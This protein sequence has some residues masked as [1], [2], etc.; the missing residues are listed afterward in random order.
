MKGGQDRR[1]Q[2]T[3]PLSYLDGRSRGHAPYASY[4]PH[5]EYKKANAWK[6]AFL[7]FTFENVALNE[8]VK[9]RQQHR[10]ETDAIDTIGQRKDSCHGQLST[11]DIGGGYHG[12]ECANS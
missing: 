3:H 9:K 6:P 4:I 11:A 2:Q 1:F 8:N 7:G 10:K 12:K 5:R